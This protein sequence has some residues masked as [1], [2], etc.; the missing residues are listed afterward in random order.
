MSLRAGWSTFGP[1]ARIAR[2]RGAQGVTLAVCSL[3]LA[4]C[5]SGDAAVLRTQLNEVQQE[6]DTAALYQLQANFHRA[7][8]A[9]DADLLMA[10]WADDATLEVGGKT[11]T[12]KEEIR[13]FVTTQLAAFQPENDW[14][15]L[16]HSPRIATTVH[17][18]SGTLNFQCHYADKMS[19]ELKSMASRRRRRLPRMVIAGCSRSSRQA[20]RHSSSTSPKGTSP[21]IDHQP[22]IGF[23]AMGLTPF[24]HRIERSSWVKSGDGLE[25][26]PGLR[27]DFHFIAEGD[28]APRV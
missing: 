15:A 4:A 20:R 14:V 25:F 28:Q 26:R 1:F 10:Q 6:A 21:R 7:V 27:A 12:G 5:G 18:S 9:K 11:Y 23:G 19:K 24:P 17:R 2:K 16:T 3:A 13:G 22:F 8:T